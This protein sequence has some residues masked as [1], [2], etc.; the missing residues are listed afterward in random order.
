MLLSLIYELQLHG[1]VYL[2]GTEVKWTQNDIESIR[3]EVVSN[4]PCAK[5]L[6]DDSES[7]RALNL[8]DDLLQQQ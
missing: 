4:N 8:K 2:H 7:M 5:E 1:L 3:K 6:E